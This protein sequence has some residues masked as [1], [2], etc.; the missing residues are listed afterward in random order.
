M[1]ATD[2]RKTF[3]ASAWWP[4]QLAERNKTPPPGEG[5]AWRRDFLPQRALL[6]R[7]DLSRRKDLVRITGVS[8]TLPTPADRDG[9]AA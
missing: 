1:T 6:I 3:A 8:A 7:G 5:L 2:C 4:A 9:A